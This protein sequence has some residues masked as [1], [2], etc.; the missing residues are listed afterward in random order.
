MGA[1]V[2]SGWVR[3]DA[4]KTYRALVYPYIPVLQWDIWWAVHGWP[5]LLIMYEPALQRTFFTRLHA[6]AFCAV[7]SL[8][9]RW[10]F[11]RLFYQWIESRHGETKKKSIWQSESDFF[12][13]LLAFF[14]PPCFFPRLRNGLSPLFV[15]WQW[16]W[17][18]NR[19][20]IP[21]HVTTISASYASRHKRL[22]AISAERG[23]D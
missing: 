7:F 19:D 10:P 5:R 13:S 14:R 1:T 4:Q 17:E 16:S 20:H 11:W 2:V 3:A 21:I 22:K 9:Q 8:R 15:V 6:A 12:A 18:C 23:E